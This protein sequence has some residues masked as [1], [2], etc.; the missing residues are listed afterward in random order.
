[1]GVS[2][3]PLVVGLRF[4]CSGW[5]PSEVIAEW[6]SGVLDMCHARGIDTEA[7]NF[8][9]LSVKMPCGERVLYKAVADMPMESVACPCG[10]PQH[11]AILMD[12]IGW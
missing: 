6:A 11:W 8:T 2:E 10:D 12:D 4:N 7:D 5:D 3:R 1:M 9:F